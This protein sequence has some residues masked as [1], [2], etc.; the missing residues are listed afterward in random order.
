MIVITWTSKRPRIRRDHGLFRF[1]DIV[2]E[3]YF[4]GAELADLEQRGKV[5]VELDNRL[6]ETVVE[7]V[8]APVDEPAAELADEPFIEPVIEPIVEAKP[9][10]KRG[11]KKS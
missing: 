11:R 6:D 5:K 1:G 7:P 9:K 8:E 4:T 3:G 2:P 10:R